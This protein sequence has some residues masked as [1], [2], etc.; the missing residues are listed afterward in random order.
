MNFH[1]LG[2]QSMGKKYANP[3]KVFARVIRINEGFWTHDFRK[4][5]PPAERD[6]GACTRFSGSLGVRNGRPGRTRTKIDKERSL[7]VTDGPYELTRIG[8]TIGKIIPPTPVPTAAESKRQN[9]LSAA[10]ILTCV[11]D[12]VGKTTPSHE[13]FS[14][15]RKAG[16]IQQSFFHHVSQNNA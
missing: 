4:V 5:P 15:E 10:S 7:R 2:S 13:P 6:P 11:H 9:S 14:H 16:R 8:M 12:P 1:V 3:C